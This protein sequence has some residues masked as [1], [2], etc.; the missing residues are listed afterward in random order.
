M[1]MSGMGRY[2]IERA[3]GEGA[4]AMVWQA[5]DPAVER[6]VAIKTLRPELARNPSYV[7]RFLREAKAAG[8]L[9]HPNIVTVFDVGEHEAQ[10]YIAM[11][12]VEGE[13]LDRVL[14]TRGA[15]PVA[16]VLAIGIQ[17][18]EA[19]A[20]AHQ[21]GIVHRDIKPANIMLCDEGRVCVLDFGIARMD[22]A[23]GNITQ[24]G[25]TL[26]S[27]RYMSPEQ[28]L[29][30][31]VDGR[32]DLF[33]SGVLLYE[34]ITGRTAFAA[35]TI[36]S[37]ALQIVRDP[38]PPIADHAPDCPPG[39][40]AIID[41]L[42]EKKPE[43]RFAGGA[44]LAAALRKEAAK[45]AK[46]K[47]GPR[48]ALPLTV[49][50]PLAAAAA[51]AAVVVPAGYWT[52]QREDA[53]S[54]RLAETS[55]QALAAFVAHN[56]ALKAVENATLPEDEQDWLP[57][58]TFIDAAV[59]NGVVRHITLSDGDRLIRAADRAGLRGQLRERARDDR[60]GDR[61]LRVS[62][63]ITYAGRKFGAIDIVVDDKA[64]SAMRAES[65]GAITWLIG[66]VMA[67][68]LMIAFAAARAVPLPPR[69]Q[70]ATPE[71]PP[72][73]APAPSVALDATVIDK[74]LAA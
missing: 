54:L 10:P 26:G 13:T 40:R 56:V 2:R 33:A 20:Y 5:F 27:P 67:T 65:R 24:I 68:V 32:S 61:A 48:F 7:T 59:R 37:L 29:G 14:E 45:L 30:E 66:A 18:A 4:M 8:T 70:T 15:L 21:R 12:L 62:S 63:P 19:L 58:Q 16:E 25:E 60:Y 42:I 43:K 17:L 1:T 31:T 52:V 22:E 35:T 53:S 46:R 73:T 11:E 69:R 47:P 36:A 3:I 38:P 74:R 71:L 44:E 51:M 64:L 39:L 41:R 72:V 49:K 55:S 57:A 28:A 50:W 23:D 6:R 9:S 34:L